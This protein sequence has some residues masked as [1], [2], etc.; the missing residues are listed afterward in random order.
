MKIRGNW[1]YAKVELTL[2]AE[3]WPAYLLR[4]LQGYDQLCNWLY[5]YTAGLK[6]GFMYRQ[7]FILL[8][9]AHVQL[10][11]ISAQPLSIDSLKLELNASSEDTNKV[12][13]YRMLCGLLRL[14]DPAEGVSYGRAGVSLGKKLDFD[15][16]VAGCYLNLSACYNSYGKLDSALHHIDTAIYYAH[17]VGEPNRLALAYLNRADAY[18]QLQNFDQSLRDCDTSLIFAERANN[19]DRRARVLQ[20][21]GSVYFFQELYPLSIEYYNKANTLYLRN[22]NL[23][24]SAIVLNNLALVH[25]NT[26]S[27][28]QAAEF[29][30]NAINIADSLD[31]KSNLSLYHGTISEVYL[32]MDMYSLAGTHAHLAMDYGRQISNDIQVGNAWQY[33]GQIYLKQNRTSEAITALTRSYEICHRLGNLENIQT[34]TKWLAEAHEAGG[35][36]QLAYTYLGESSAASDTLARQRFDDN[37]TAM[38]TRF[39][40]D[41]KDREIQLLNLDREIQYQ[42]LS[43]QRIL[44]ISSIALTILLLIGIVLY[45]SRYK[46]RNRMKE[47]ELRHRIAADL[48]DEVGSSL[49]SIHML[50]QIAMQSD[51]ASAGKRD[52]LARM[53]MNAKETMDKM[54]DIVW[55][56]KPGESAGGSLKQRMERFAF[57]MCNDADIEIATDLS[58]LEK[59]KFSMDQRKNLYLIFKE[60]LNNALKYSKTDRI[61]ITAKSEESALKLTVRDY[62]TGFDEE[63]VKTGNGLGNM[64]TR[65]K[66]LMG[67]LTIITDEGKGTTVQVTVPT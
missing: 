66:E 52:I 9:A 26:G 38:Q 27:Y 64:R 25:K 20:T 28:T 55:M 19:D 63:M 39:R 45:I 40:V 43:S 8:V 57:E 56:I 15:K 44:I 29:L 67:K 10:G 48:H 5:L 59:V 65:A 34:V 62:G 6:Q 33:L 11:Q 16:G 61:A 46:L 13:L 54:S 22:N 17:R 60:A 50:S 58:D 37:I 47:L 12:I 31:D 23:Q 51:P 14:S 24:M 7:I 35:N 4:V 32:H 30:L 21:I 3:H 49:S 41:E 18:M 36:Y 42:R 1:R 2:P 53:S